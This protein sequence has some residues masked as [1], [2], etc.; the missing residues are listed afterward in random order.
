[1]MQM[2]KRFSGVAWILAGL[3]LGCS[4]AAP[5]QGTTETTQPI[6]FG[7]VVSPGTA[8]DGPWVTIESASNR[9]GYV[10]W[11]SGILVS[12]DTVLTAAHV[13]DNVKTFDVAVSRGNR[14]ATGANKPQKILA[15]TIAFHRSYHQFLEVWT[16]SPDGTFSLADGTRLTPQQRD[17]KIKDPGSVAF[18]IG[19]DLALIRLKQPFPTNGGWAAPYCNRSDLDALS[20]FDVVSGGVLRAGFSNV[21]VKNSATFSVDNPKYTQLSLN[22]FAGQVEYLHLQ[23]NDITPA[24]KQKKR[25]QYIIGGDSGS[26]VLLPTSP[27]DS[28]NVRNVAGII[29][30]GGDPPGT[31]VANS[32]LLEPYCQWIQTVMNKLHS[33]ADFDVRE[34]IKIDDYKNKKLKGTLQRFIASLSSD[35]VEVELGAGDQVATYRVTLPTPPSEIRNSVV[36][37]FSDRNAAI[38]F[39]DDGRIVARNVFDD[40]ALPIDV[41][42]GTE[43]K[44][45]LVVNATSPTQTY[46]DLIA[47]KHDQ[48]GADLYRGG[49]NGLTR[50]GVEGIAITRIDDDAAADVVLLDG[51]SLKV[52]TGDSVNSTTLPFSPRESAS[53]KFTRNGVTAGRD[54]AFLS[55][56]GQVALCAM[57]SDAAFSGSCAS[58]TMPSGVSAA[59]IRATYFDSDQFEDLEVTAEDGRVAIFKGSASGLTFSTF[60]Q[61]MPSARTDDGKLEL[62]SGTQ[63]DTLGAPVSEFYVSE[64]V[65]ASG[66]PTGQPLIVQLYDAGIYGSFDGSPD[67]SDVSTCVNVYAS[68]TPGAA[69]ETLVKSIGETEYGPRELSWL[70][71]FDSSVDGHSSEAV[72]ASG[73]RWY[74]VE[75]K[76]VRTDDECTAAPVVDHAAF[77]GFKLR[78]SGQLRSP[79]GHA[80]YGSDAFGAFSSFES[81]PD[82]RFDGT[83]DIPFYVGGTTERPEIPGSVPVGITLRQADADDADHE[84]DADGQRDDIYFRLFRGTSQDGVALQ[85][86]RTDGQIED[87]LNVATTTVEDPSGNAS[88]ASGLF[89]THTTEGLGTIQ[90]GLHT[91]HWANVGAENAIQLQPVTGSPINHEFIAHGGRWLGSSGALEPAVLGALADEEIDALLPV[92]IGDAGFGQ[93]RTFNSKAAIRKGLAASGEDDVTALLSREL[94]ALKLNVKRARLKNEPLEAAFVLSTRVSVGE[95]LKKVDTLLGGGE[96]DLAP[97]EALRLMAVAN[98]GELTYLSPRELVLASAD[99]DA[100]GIPDAG[101]NCAMKANADQLDTNGDGIGD[102]CEPTPTVWCVEPRSRGGMTAVF[103]YESPLRDFRVPA[104]ERN[105]LS[106]EGVEQV[107]PV[108][109]RRGV[110][111]QAVTVPFEGGSVTWTVLG[112]SVTATTDAPRCSDVGAGSAV[113]EASTSEFHCCVSIADCKAASDFGLYATETIRMGQRVRVLDENGRPGSVLSLGSIVMEAEAEAGDIAGGGELVV[114]DRVGLFG[115]IAVAGSLTELGGDLSPRVRKVPLDA[116]DLSAFSRPFSGSAGVEVENGSGR[117]R[118][119]DPGDYGRARFAGEVTLVAGEYHFTTLELLESGTLRIDAADGPVIVH[120]GGSV[121]L[122]G[123]VL[124]EPGDLLIE[125]HGQGDV[126]VSTNLAATIIAP[127]GRIVVDR[128]GSVQFGAFYAR[129]IELAADVT[130]V[131]QRPLAP[132]L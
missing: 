36:G 45:L 65:N 2:Y 94:L 103:G 26:G 62:L 70:T 57:T 117:N 112:K 12:K 69:N 68:P 91:W 84:G 14:G 93:L 131:R 102:R 27:K 49:P 97:E 19:V 76:L 123:A 127:D 78:T 98:S 44:D 28:P 5:D 72:S 10:S 30:T 128:A 63:A 6:H 52:V 58:L 1:M 111:R 43:Y 95:L 35:G 3:G 60:V 88:G 119:L 16:V 67:G 9:P 18:R 132:R 115:D 66:S 41:P 29:S 75:L 17:A 82:T 89:E 11:G 99:R 120:V 46:N 71:A 113:C 22:P 108:L 56:G 107:P 125:L 79:N 59:A 116:P 33:D 13:V 50:A 104:G 47:I 86:K 80:L 53:G 39:L 106:G 55:G 105:E 42:S 38:V 90:S 25:W 15:Q 64:P 101:D 23:G 96:V 40:T 73:V 129:A 130:H 122:K 83:F 114:G 109:F 34:E 110:E 126:R 31:P 4:Q 48:F 20:Q 100:D 51:S 54:L 7:D 24:G 21:G 85:V 74:R 118:A 87:D 61:G 121:S 32:I 8:I 77:N 92:E 37:S 124:A 81:A